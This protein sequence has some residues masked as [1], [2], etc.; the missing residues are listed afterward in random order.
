[1]IRMLSDDHDHFNVPEG[2]EL[3]GPSHAKCEKSEK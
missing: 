2:D 1:M 3:A